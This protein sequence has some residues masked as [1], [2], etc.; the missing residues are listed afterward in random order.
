[1]PVRPSI[2]SNIRYADGLAAIDFLC[3]AFGF[4]EHAVY[5]DPEQPNVIAHAQLVRDGQMIMLSSAQ[6]TPFSAAAPMVTVAQAGGNTQSIYVVLDDVDAHASTARE[7]GADIFME[8]EDQPQGGRS[9]SV[10]DLERN[11][12]TFGSYDPFAS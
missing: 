3:R 10:R 1:M 2:I 5:R 12:W 7:H 9:Y 6:A 4:N 11:A 8:P